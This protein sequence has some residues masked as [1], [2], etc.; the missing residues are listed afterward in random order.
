MTANAACL[1][2]ATREMG[3]LLHTLWIGRNT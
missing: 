1:S 2:A 3:R